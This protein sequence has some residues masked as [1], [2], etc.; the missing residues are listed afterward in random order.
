MQL[1]LLKKKV[2]LKYFENIDFNI[3]L[4]YHWKNF[5]NIIIDIPYTIKKLPENN[6][7]FSSD[8]DNCK[9]I[10][11]AL[12]IINCENYVILNLFITN[13]IRFINKDMH[14]ELLNRVKSVKNNNLFPDNIINKCSLKE[15]NNYDVFKISLMIKIIK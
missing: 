11:D 14:V 12:Q 1:Y 5:K 2:I 10:D 13:V 4:T 15:N 8:P 9:I 3:M 7:V 6:I